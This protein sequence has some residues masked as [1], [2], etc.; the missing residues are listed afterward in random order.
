MKQTLFWFA[1]FAW[2]AFNLVPVEIRAEEEC[3]GP[4]YTN[5]MCQ[6]GSG[7]AQCP[8]NKCHAT[9]DDP[10]PFSFQCCPPTAG[11]PELPEALG[12]F[13]LA[14]ALLGLLYL[15]KRWKKTPLRPAELPNG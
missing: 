12:P 7:I 9:N 15:K 13:T 4:T 14:L 1:A 11:V 2:I 6:D 10:N 3:S 8:P 5:S